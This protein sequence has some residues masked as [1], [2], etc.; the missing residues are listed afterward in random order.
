MPKKRSRSRFFSGKEGTPGVG[1]LA[2]HPE[3][4]PGPNTIFVE[5][6]TDTSITNDATLTNDDELFF[7]VRAGERWDIHLVIHYLSVQAADIQFKLDVPGTGATGSG[8][9]T[10]VKLAATN[11]EELILDFASL[12]VFSAG[13]IGGTE[14][15]DILSMDWSIN[16]LVGDA[17]GRITLQWC[18]SS[19]NA[20]TTKVYAGSWIF[21]TKVN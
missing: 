14:P 19:S 21:A 1:A 15:G 18:Q 7:D 12:S 20:N 9:N 4:F 8:V 10:R 17:D 13:G 3:L 16:V 6:T 2:E 11:K 5:K